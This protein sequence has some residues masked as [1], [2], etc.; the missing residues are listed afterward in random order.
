MN[1][2]DALKTIK[3]NIIESNTLDETADA[4]LQR[5]AAFFGEC[6]VDESF[7]GLSIDE[8]RDSSGKLQ[9]IKL[10]ACDKVN[11]EP[12]RREGKFALMNGDMRCLETD[13]PRILVS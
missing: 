3:G 13:K 10:V 12:E 2:Q 7:C 9:S 1:T 4:L 6:A 11:G 8:S 5:V